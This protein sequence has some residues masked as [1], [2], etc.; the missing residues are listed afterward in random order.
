[1]YS[2][3]EFQ[4]SP[5]DVDAPTFT[6]PQW[7]RGKALLLQKS[8]R[9]V[10]VISPCTGLNAPERASREMGMDWVSAGDYEL[11]QDLHPVL[12]IISGHHGRLHIGRVRGDVTMVPF[13]RPRPLCRCVGLRTTVPALF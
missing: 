9:P 8:L 1:M 13:D 6:Q 5:L 11:N 10:R 4:P 7:A 2:D 3:F 12:N